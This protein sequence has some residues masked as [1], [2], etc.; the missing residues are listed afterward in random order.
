MSVQ[1]SYFAPTC[2]YI[3]HNAYSPTH[4][5][6]Q[7]PVPPPHT[8]NTYRCAH[9]AQIHLFRHSI[10]PYPFPFPL[11]PATNPPAYPTPLRTHALTHACTHT[12]AHIHGHPLPHPTGVMEPK[13]SPSWRRGQHFGRR[14]VEYYAHNKMEHFRGWVHTHQKELLYRMTFARVFPFTPNWYAGCLAVRPKGGGT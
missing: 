5:Y 8:R 12:C 14:F 9:I 10:T 11:T 6:T 2:K 3:H 13:Y 7:S 4:I 1:A